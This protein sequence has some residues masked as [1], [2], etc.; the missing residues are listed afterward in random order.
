MELVVVKLAAYSFDKMALS[1]ITNC[2]IILVKRIK[3]SD[4]FSKGLE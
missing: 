4:K 1:L 2:L 3:L